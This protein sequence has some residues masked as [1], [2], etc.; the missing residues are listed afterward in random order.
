[1]KI[2][3]V[4]KSY[5][6]YGGAE[7][8]LAQLIGRLSQQG[9]DIH[10]FANRWEEGKGEEPGGRVSFHPVPMIRAP[11]FMEALSFALFSKRLLQEETFDIIHSFERTLYQDIYRAGD[12]CH[13][14]WLI[15]R[16]KIDPWLKRV[17]YP[18][19]PLHLS[20]LFLEK[21]LYRSPKLKRVVANS[22]RGKEEIIRHYGVPPEKIE[23]IYNGVD[24]DVF[25]P[26]NVALYRRPMREELRID[27]EAYVILFLG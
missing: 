14:E 17:S 10:V 2:A 7:R 26:R 13:R 22:T 25:H 8:Y 5:T 27:P 11:S 1:M 12:G 3:L 4:R 9:H 6:P 24:L 18:I 19:N 23:V 16:E 15:Q 20:L 21:K